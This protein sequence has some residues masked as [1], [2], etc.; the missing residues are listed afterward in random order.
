MKF[1]FFISKRIA[2]KA[3]GSF[4]SSI[5]RLAIFAVS[6][7]I[8]IM[9]LSACIVNGFQTEIEKKMFGFWGHIQVVDRSTN[10]FNDAYPLRAREDIESHIKGHPNV[11]SA[12]RFANKAGILKSKTE[13]EGVALKGI[14]PDYD[15]DF[16]NDHIVDGEAFR[17][18]DNDTS[19][20]IL[21]SQTMAKRIKL[22]VGDPVRFYYIKKSTKGRKLHVSGIYHTGMDEFDKLYA[23]V[24]IKMIQDLNRWDA[25][26]VSGYEIITKDIYKISQTDGEIAQKLDLDKRTNSVHELFPTMFDWIDLTVQN[27]YI[28]LTLVIIVTAFNM[29]TVLLIL[30]LER[31]NMI[32]ILKALGT[33]D[34]TIQKIFI[35]NVSYIAGIGL[36]IGNAAALLFSWGQSTFGW[37]KLPERSYYLAQIPIEIHW[38]TI[39]L[40]NAIAITSI[41]LILILPTLVVK[42]ITPIK[43]IRFE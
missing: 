25:N 34:W 2:K 21:I 30:V 26:E 41:I 18:N 11:K 35:I 17:L 23:F 33:R 6:I 20:G 29:M 14:G 43:A 39:I 10:N 42:R 15:W 38:P 36:I 24:D 3:G 37:I 19:R 28:I 22:K 7:S 27:K 12:H 4:S 16:L 9:T 13:I 32:G 5:I 40:L 8:F 1:E 31:T